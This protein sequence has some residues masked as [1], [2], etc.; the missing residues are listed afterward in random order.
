MVSFVQIAF[1][2]SKTFTEVFRESSD[3]SS[4][5]DLV[6]QDLF[7]CPFEAEPIPISNQCDGEMDCSAA[8]EWDCNGDSDCLNDRGCVDGSP[9]FVSVDEYKCRSANSLSCPHSF[10]QVPSAN[11]KMCYK[12]VAS[13]KDYTNAMGACHSLL[14][15]FFACKPFKSFREVTEK[16]EKVDKS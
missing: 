6:Q 13:Q 5:L 11:K 4:C 16:S 10:E 9:C 7:K 12:A 14:V 1:E 15:I 2:T 8:L 3:F